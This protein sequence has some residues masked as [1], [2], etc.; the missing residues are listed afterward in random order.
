M[1]NICRMDRWHRIISMKYCNFLV[2]AWAK[3]E[4]RRIMYF[5][6]PSS[7]DVK[8]EHSRLLFCVLKSKALSNNLPPR[9]INT[10]FQI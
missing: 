10:T 2:V 3:F 7:F 6:F 8:Q 1:V 9:I 4:I 5:F